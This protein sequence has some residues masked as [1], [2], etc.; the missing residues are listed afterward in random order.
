[1]NIRNMMEGI[2][3]SL[4]LEVLKKE[5]RL[6]ESKEYFEDICAYVLNRLPAKY[7]TS[8]RGILHG[9]LE[10]K[11]SAQQKSDIIMLVYEAMTII[12][13]RRDKNHKH[14]HISKGAP[15]FFFPHL[16]G[17]VLEKT[18]FSKI[19]G[20]KVTLLKDKSPVKMVSDG[21][22]NP[23]HTNDG[24]GSYY[25]FWPLFDEESDPLLEQKFLVTFEHEKFKPFEQ[26]IYVRPVSLT[27][28]AIETRIVAVVLLDLKE[29]EDLS[30]LE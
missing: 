17:E 13:E 26:D 4:V 28:G 24:T 23:F 8:D 21:W 3:S 9:I 15:N 19:P 11:F 30:F 18:T 2:V 5:E 14:I 7:V 22:D 12:H 10:T 6:N 29:G 20:V 25:H 27:S 1:M 16:L